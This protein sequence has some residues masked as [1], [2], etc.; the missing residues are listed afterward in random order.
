[1][2]WGNSNPR[3]HLRCNPSWL[4]G[5]EKHPV[6]PRSS[7]LA[8]FDLWRI[9]SDKRTLAQLRSWTSQRRKYAGCSAR[10]A[11]RE[12]TSVALVCAQRAALAVN[13]LLIDMCAQR[14]PPAGPKGSARDGDPAK[15]RDGDAGRSGAWEGRREGGTGG[16]PLSRDAPCARRA[17]V[18]AF[19][20]SH[21]PS[22]G[23]KKRTR[24]TIA[25]S[26]SMLVPRFFARSRC[27]M[28]RTP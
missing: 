15:S 10:S 9:C 14:P 27:R 18:A 11:G 6:I 26:D 12:Q 4:G 20:V 24:Q 7:S 28:G 17:R 22:R 25:A 21:R 3:P 2:R 5:F 8:A 16:G 19:A 23:R 13:I 1:M